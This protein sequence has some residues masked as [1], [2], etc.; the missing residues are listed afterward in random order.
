[1]VWLDRARPWRSREERPS[2]ARPS[3]EDD[4]GFVGPL[5]SWVLPGQRPGEN[6]PGSRLTSYDVAAQAVRDTVQNADGLVTYTP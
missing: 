1:M 5:P 3:H 6:R 2:R 4:S